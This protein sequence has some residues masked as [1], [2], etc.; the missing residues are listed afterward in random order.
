VLFERGVRLFRVFRQALGGLLP[1][2][3]ADPRLEQAQGVVPESIDLDG[4]AASRRHH[5]VIHL[6]IHPRQLVAFLTLPEQAILDI[7]ADI[8]MRAT[9]MV[10]DDIQ[11]FGKD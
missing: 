1:L 4:F 6:G 11:K 8:E 3:F 2:L 5:P 7:D 10:F 9:P